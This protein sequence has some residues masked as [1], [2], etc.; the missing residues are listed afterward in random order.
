MAGNNLLYV[1]VAI[2]FGA[3]VFPIASVGGSI[4][5][6]L[7]AITLLQ[8]TSVILSGFFIFAGISQ[9]SEFI[10]NLFGTITL[11]SVGVMIS[12]F[13]GGE[14]VYDQVN[15]DYVFDSDFDANGT[16]GQNLEEVDGYLQFDS[17]ATSTSPTTGSYNSTIIQT[18]G[19]VT[20]EDLIV[21]I[22]DW[23]DNN[24]DATLNVKVYNEQDIKSI[25]HTYNLSGGDNRLNVSKINEAGIEGHSFSFEYSVTTQ[26][27]N[28]EAPRLDYF[29][30]D[31]VENVEQETGSY[32]FIEYLVLFVFVA[33]GL[34]MLFS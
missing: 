10:T 2:F 7:T 8:A 20:F 14:A 3:M 24:H 27:T 21:K 32:G 16:V 18:E 1:A 5:L 26:E 23:N 9:K 22:E 13:V 12:M 25:E 29:N 19:S 31:T 33:G 17:S 4:G 11:V 30:F 6:G 34:F 28:K 15:N